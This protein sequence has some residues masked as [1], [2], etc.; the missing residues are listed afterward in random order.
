MKQKGKTRLDE[1]LLAALLQGGNVSAAARKGGVSTRTAQRRLADSDFQEKFRVAKLRVIRETTAKL[2]AN[3]R[4][5]ADN[6]RKVFDDR[7]ATAG[8]RV[9]A[10]TSTIRLTLEAFEIEE[11]E[12]R[13]RRLEESQKNAQRF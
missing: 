4:R 1:L 8:A 3:S 9:A 6:L 11:L 12:E 2:T 10:A 5:A 13:I 7:K